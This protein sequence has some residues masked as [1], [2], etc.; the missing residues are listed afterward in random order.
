MSIKRFSFNDTPNW[1]GAIG[2]QV[3]LSLRFRPSDNAIIIQKGSLL[4][5][6]KNETEIYGFI[7][8]SDEVLIIPD[9]SQNYYITMDT[10]G[11]FY[12]EAGN[13]ENIHG[14]GA[15]VPGI[16]WYTYNNR[17][18]L[19]KVFKQNLFVTGFIVCDDSFWCE[20]EGVF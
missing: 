5:G 9:L 12:I 20:F 3:R 1:K 7:I 15:D 6:L 11:S 19:G 17:A 10:Q 2:F 16:P 4:Y 13:P 18:L 14:L 8:G